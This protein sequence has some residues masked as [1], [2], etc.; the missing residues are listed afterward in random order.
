M[1]NSTVER[2]QQVWL[3]R[4]L[5]WAPRARVVSVGF[6]VALLLT[7]AVLVFVYLQRAEQSRLV[8][9]FEVQTANASNGLR[10]RF[11]VYQETVESIS[12]LYATGLDLNRESF[13]A[14]V[15]RTIS[16]YDGIHA[17]GWNP[18]VKHDERA[19]YEQLARNDGLEDFQFKQWTPDSDSPWT[20]SGTKWADEYVPAWLLEPF[21]DNRFAI[22]I[23]VA[24]NPTR[25]EALERAR[26]TGQAV[27]TAR[28]TLAQDAAEQAG[29]LIFVPVY[30]VEASTETIIDRR[31]SLKGFA[32]GV[33]RVGSIVDQVIADL[34]LDSIQV[35]I[36]DLSAEDDQRLLFATGSDQEND[37]KE[38][39]SSDAHTRPSTA[40]EYD[41]GGRQWLIEFAA[42][43]EYE[44]ARR[45]WES[46]LLLF[47][48]IGSSLLL[49]VVLHLVIGRASE[50]EGQVW[51]KTEQLRE[52]NSLLEQEILDRERAQSELQTKAAEL[53]KSNEYLTR[54]N[55]SAT[56]REM[57]MVELKK[58][59]NDLLESAEQPPRYEVDFAE[60]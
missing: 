18:L 39:L 36:T 15:T 49:G 28:I 5:A 32:V 10:A 24:S 25:R 6:P 41:V 52:A 29:F 55:R 33:F 14:F 2:G 40:F 22:G 7:G 38:G 19:A 45:R 34:E 35:R 13:K 20:A 53:E 60:K 23:D 43:P 16:Q 51:L 47:G 3:D 17:L 27:A 44:D 50:V 21:E 46:W 42:T 8:A 12:S 54:F 37:S 11:D 1:R 48:G 30:T 56:G 9:D 26:D 31:A 4:F 58:E 57:R 59:V